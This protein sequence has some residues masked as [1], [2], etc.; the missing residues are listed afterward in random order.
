M[1]L[2]SD[3]TS[4]IAIESEKPDRAAQQLNSAE[5]SRST[6]GFDAGGANAPQSF[7][8]PKASPVQKVSQ[9]FEIRELLKVGDDK[10]KVAGVLYPLQDLSDSEFESIRRRSTSQINPWQWILA[11]SRRESY[12]T[13][14]E[15]FTRIKLVVAEQTG[16]SGDA[17]ALLTFWAFSTW[18]KEPLSLAP[19]LVITGWAHEGELI[20]RTLRL[21]CCRPLLMAGLTSANL[22]LAPLEWSLTLLISEPKLSKQ[23]ALFL[24]SSTSRG[25]QA[26]RDGDCYD[27][28]GFKAIYLGEDLPTKPLTHSVHVNASDTQ[29]SESHRT[30]SLSEKTV[31]SFQ[32]QLHN[33]RVTNL[34]RVFRSDFNASGLSPESNAIA[35]ALGSCIVD[36]PNL[37]AE[38]VSLLMPQARQQMAER[39][40]DLGSVAVGAALSLCH[41]DKDKI[42]VGE[43]AAEV[44][45]ILRKRGERVQFSAEK[46]GHKLKRIGLLSRR[47]GSAGNGFL[48]DRATQ[49]RLHEVGV[50]YGC[51][52]FVEAEKS[53]HCP[54]CQINKGS[55]DVL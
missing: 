50:A 18:F 22:S 38:L 24:S 55:V 29:M 45:R 36:A 2:V 7:K 53:L 3:D 52:G 33:Y 49:V 39:F 48:L 21:F 6:D 5:C 23:M 44:N 34:Q 31:E 25:Y 40:D 20:L 51:G 28:F 35:N 13:T 10:A 27:Y 54:L 14:V 15:L 11:P 1:P 46:V 37:Q 47:L 12:G 41:E 26:M 30:R 8:T 4:D 17:S 19:C 42:L 9:V 32:N 16:L 43:I